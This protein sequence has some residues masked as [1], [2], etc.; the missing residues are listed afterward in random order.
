MVRKKKEEK[1]AECRKEERNRGEGRWKKKRNGDGK[2]EYDQ[3]GRR[4]RRETR[5]TRKCKIDKRCEECV[6]MVYLY[7]R[8]R[9]RSV[10]S[11][12]K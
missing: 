2:E 12:E 4:T 7:S 10:W 9:E 6:V 5:T 1:V 11:R 3:A 8:E